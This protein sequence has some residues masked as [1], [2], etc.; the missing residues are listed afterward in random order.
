ML[1]AKQCICGSTQFEYEPD[2]DVL[3]CSECC[4]LARL[5]L[6]NDYEWKG[7]DEDVKFNNS[8]RQN[9]Q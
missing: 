3:R 6:I 9:M 1:V 7:T 4:R 8:I 5:I 2:D